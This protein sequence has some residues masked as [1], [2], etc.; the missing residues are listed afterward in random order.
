MGGHPGDKHYVFFGD[1]YDAV[2]AAEIGDPEYKGFK[3]VGL[4]EYCPPDLELWTTYCWRIDEKRFGEPTVKGMVWCFTT[5]CEIMP[6]DI[7]LDCIV[8]GRDWAMLADDWAKEAF[9]PDDF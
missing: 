6:G 4:E 7:N 9:F 3:P 2:A 5:G 8:D 1:D